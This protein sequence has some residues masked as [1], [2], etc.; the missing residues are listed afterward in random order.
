[1]TSNRI[2][3]FNI[4]KITAEENKKR[5]YFVLKLLLFA[6]LVYLG[7]QFS[8]MKHTDGVVRRLFKTFFFFVPT[9][10]IIS[11]SR[12]LIAY[13]YLKQNNRPENFKDN[14]VIGI[15]KIADIL[16]FF[17]LII[18]IFV[19]FEYNIIEFLTSISI[20]AAAIA[21]LSKD[22]I[23]NM[24][25][26][27]II[28]FS[29]QLS[30]NDDVKIGSQKGKVIN[31]TLINVHLLNEDD[32]LIFIPNNAVFATDVVNYTK[33]SVNKVTIEFEMAK[34]QAACLQEMEVYLKSHLRTF[35]KVIH[36]ESIELCIDHISR[37][38]V[39]MKL[40]FTLVKHSSELEREAKQNASLYILNFISNKEKLTRLEREQRLSIRE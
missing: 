25:N 34:D 7:M 40:H 36:Q 11:L 13:W 8:L 24:I 5:L 12:L 10:L 6:G 22:Y 31:I 38:A 20:V 4:E 2:I 30:I 18:S 32:D 37:E 29:N 1:M 17:A 33:H 28:M 23:S 35:S 16:S 3:K 27:M 21:L 39:Y 15:N 19:L 14:F 9:N 26:G